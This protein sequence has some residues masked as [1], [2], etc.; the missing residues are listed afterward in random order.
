MGFKVYGMNANFLLCKP[1]NGLEAKD[2]YDYLVDQN[3]FIRYFNQKRLADKLRISIGTEKEI[4]ILLTHLNKL[5][6]E[7]EMPFEPNF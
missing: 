3:I 6:S 2:I 7:R 5:V 1:E 4:D